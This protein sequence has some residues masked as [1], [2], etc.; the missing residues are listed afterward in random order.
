LTHKYGLWELPYL[1][2]LILI[3]NIHVMHQERNVAESIIRTRMNFLEKSKDNKQARKHLAMICHRPSL[4]LSARGTK[5]QAPFCMK[6][7]ERKEVMTWMKNLKFPNG[8]MT[9]FRRAINLKTGKFTGVKSHDY[10]VIMEW[11][12]PNILRGYVHKD[13]WKTLAELSY[14]YRQLCAK[15]IKKQMMEK[16]EKEIPVLL[17]KLEKIF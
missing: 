4:H 13:V 1:K 14:F 6:A 7:K 15:E 10:H 16:L 17:C 5:P 9:G 2:A 12:L 11:L 3:H 8:F